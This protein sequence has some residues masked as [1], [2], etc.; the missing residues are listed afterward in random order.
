MDTFSTYHPC[1]D[2]EVTQPETAEWSS[3]VRRFVSTRAY[4][5]GTTPLRSWLSTEPRAQQA[6]LE[7]VTAILKPCT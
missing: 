4:P 7:Y 6:V 1:S 3:L 2:V 5:L